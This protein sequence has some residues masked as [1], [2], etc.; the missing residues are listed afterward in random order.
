MSNK[1]DLI[2]NKEK[3]LFFQTA[4]FNCVTDRI[5][6]LKDGRKISFASQSRVSAC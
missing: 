4:T 1:M 3:F 6:T 2:K 5:A